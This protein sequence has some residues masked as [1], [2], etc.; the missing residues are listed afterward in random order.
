[1]DF[2]LWT[3]T[4]YAHYVAFMVVLGFVLA[5]AIWLAPHVEWWWN[6]LQRWGC[7]MRR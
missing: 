2:L 7:A 6:R 5:L 4:L 1:V 3:L